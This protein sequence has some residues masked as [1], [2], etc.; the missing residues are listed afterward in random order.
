MFKSNEFKYVLFFIIQS[1]IL[2]ILQTNY[3]E[4]LPCLNHLKEEQKN[5]YDILLTIIMILYMC[6]VSLIY[7]WHNFYQENKSQL[8]RYRLRKSNAVLEERN[9]YLQSFSMATT[10]SLKTPLFIIKNFLEIIESNI[11][12]N[13]YSTVNHYYIKL[14]RD[15]SNMCERYSND[16]IQYTTILGMTKNVQTINVK[17][18][19][20]VIIDV[21]IL[22]HPSARITNE[23]DDI[24][25]P[26]DKRLFEIIVEN[27]ID[28]GLSYNISKMPELT[29]FSTAEDKMLS[30]FFKDNGIGIEDPY[31]KKIFEPFNRI[32][33][34]ETTLGSG[35]GLTISKFA[36]KKLNANLILASSN[37]SGSIFKLQMC[38]S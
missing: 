5:L 3:K 32:N 18:S 29:I 25:I 15:S 23:I 4:Y 14:I 12:K 2:L 6:C 10:H 31:K 16:L 27:L 28:N 1:F 33:E 8:M 7:L 26:L 24:D 17:R 9:N 21:I 38:I 22:K 37:R 20:D 35:L 11:K 13:D 34:I 36:A 30:L 19:I